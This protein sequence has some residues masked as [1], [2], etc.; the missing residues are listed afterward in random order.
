MVPSYLWTSKSCNTSVVVLQKGIYQKNSIFSDIY[1]GE[2]VFCCCWKNGKDIFLLSR[3]PFLYTLDKLTPFCIL[4]F[5]NP[6]ITKL[7]VLLD[8]NLDFC[9]L[10][11]WIIWRLHIFCKSSVKNILINFMTNNLLLFSVKKLEPYSSHS[12]WPYWLT[13]LKYTRH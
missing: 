8:G 2:N 13:Y 5:S 7:H 6:L 1:E 10:C 9:K 4:L 12:N 11:S 3:N